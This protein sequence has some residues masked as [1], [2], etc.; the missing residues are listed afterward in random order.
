MSEHKIKRNMRIFGWTKASHK[1]AVRY[2]SNEREDR[3]YRS[4]K[5]KK[6]CRFNNGVHEFKKQELDFIRRIYCHYVCIH[7]GKQK[8]ESS[9]DTGILV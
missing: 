6:K 8:W 3:P 4:L 7:C 2:F 1:S 5:R 9:K